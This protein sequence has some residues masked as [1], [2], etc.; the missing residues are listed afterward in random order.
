MGC[1]EKG[2]VWKMGTFET[3]AIHQATPPETY[4]PIYSPAGQIKVG[5]AVLVG[6]VAGALGGA[7][8]VATQRFQSS[9]AAGVE[10][11]GIDRA[12]A[13]K[14]KASPEKQVDKKQADKKEE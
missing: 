5:A 6:A 10:R 9:Q 14:L 8:W 12:Y 3:V 7:T 11:V 2:V 1:T 4:P 13:E